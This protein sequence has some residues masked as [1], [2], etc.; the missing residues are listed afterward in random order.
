[1]KQRIKDSLF[2]G[3]EIFYNKFRK[4]P[5]LSSKLIRNRILING[6][7]TKDEINYIDVYDFIF[8]NKNVITQKLWDKF[9]NIDFK[10]VLRILLRHNKILKYV[11]K[12]LGVYYCPVSREY[13]I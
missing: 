1:M 9:Q 4:Y 13:G 11:G 6:G 8:E 5:N 3:V 12:D 2:K 10:N 7:L